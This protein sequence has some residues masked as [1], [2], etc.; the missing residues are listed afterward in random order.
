VPLP[1]AAASASFRCKNC[2][3]PTVWDPDVDALKC[4]HCEAVT[5][6]PRAQ[7]S[8]VER[9]LEARAEAQRGLG[10]AVRASRCSSCG[11]TVT[12]GETETATACVFC[13][14]A[15]V[16]PQEANR[17]A[18]RP[19][20]LIPLDVG[21]AKVEQAFRAWIGSRWFRPNALKQTRTFQAI[22]VYVP[23]WTFDCAVHSQW[24]ADAGYYYYVTVPATILVN[25][26]PQ[27]VMRQERR[28]RWEP[29]WGERDDVYDDLLVL[30]SK[31]ISN[32]LADELGGF[33]LKALVPYRPEYLAGWRAEEY[34]VDL[35]GG[36]EAGK[37]RIAA[38]QQARCAGDVPGDTQRNLAVHNT[39]SEIRWKH[40]LLPVW[41]LSYQFRGRPYS[42]LIHG[43]TAKIVGE[44]PLSWLKI[45]LLIASVLAAAGI[46]AVAA[47][48]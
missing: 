46:L 36:W 3:A 15:N 22:G 37:Q 12:L 18:L 48:S 35:E 10:L 26:K 40:V 17:N 43:Q 23:Y 11:A 27:V 33:E 38:A 7:T 8:I 9:P 45:G 29:A 31:G 1:K 39:L 44:A 14:S 24:S 2:G 34:Q 13:G 20:S 30:A 42:V 6:V 28:V 47:N 32:E 16:L 5:P 41:S 21:R 19:E 4:A 25:G